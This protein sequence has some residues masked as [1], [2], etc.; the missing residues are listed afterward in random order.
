[1]NRK[2]I[3]LMARLAIFE[4]ENEEMLRQ[5]GTSYRSDYL[6]MHLLKNFCR[7]VLA[8]LLG[9]LLWFC[10]NSEMVLE[11]LNRMDIGSLTVSVCIAFGIMITLFLAVTYLVYAVHFFQAEKRLSSYKLMLERLESEYKEE[12]AKIRPRKRRD[13]GRRR[14]G[15]NT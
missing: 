12:E 6:G 15:S 3:R 13:A 9:L 8:F 2:R 10:A 5:A 14:R 11:K 4:T 1:M 7:G